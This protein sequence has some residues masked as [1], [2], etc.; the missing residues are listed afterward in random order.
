MKIPLYIISDLMCNDFIR[1]KWL[2]PKL[3]MKTFIHTLKLTF[4]K[5][6]AFVLCQTVRSSEAAM[7]KTYLRY[8]TV[9][10]GEQ[11]LSN[12]SANITPGLIL[13]VNLVVGSGMHSSLLP[14]PIP[15]ISL[16]TLGQYFLVSKQQPSLV[17]YALVG[18]T[19][20]L[21]K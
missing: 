18:S 6:T 3:V 2:F 7:N 4:N 14:A 1:Q 12:T 17:D 11:F 16:P 19:S 15:H 10:C 20:C 21:R 9:Q 5:Y 13:L 8:L